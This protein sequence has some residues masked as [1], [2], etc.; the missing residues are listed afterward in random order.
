MPRAPLPV[1]LL[2]QQLRSLLQAMPAAAAGDRESVH[3][4][5]VASRRLRE[6]LPLLAEAA[7]R[8]PLGRMRKLVRRVTRALGPVRELDVAIGHLEQQGPRAGVSPRALAAVRQSLETERQARRRDMLDRLK[9]MAL[10]KLKKSLADATSTGAA[11][12]PASGEVGQASQRAARRAE[13]LKAAIDR[14]GGLY[15][16][17]RLHR[18]RVAAKKLRYALEV[19]RDLRRSRAAA[20]INTLKGLQ[21]RLGLM[22]DYE[23]LMDR[24]RNVQGRL[25][26]SDRPTVVELDA[27]VRTLEEECRGEHAAYMH[28]RPRILQLCGRIGEAAEA[29]GPTVA[30]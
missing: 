22:H 21:D 20:R 12:P 16:P 19:E 25:A 27:L 29:G 13:A 26:L 4:A 14:A 2:R 5:R 30:A 18:V 10:E 9:P 6:A 24:I 15:L 1:M 28:T 17:D 8:A 7:G 11:V 23:V 3:K